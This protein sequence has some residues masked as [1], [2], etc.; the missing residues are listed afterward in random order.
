M[1]RLEIPCVDS[2]G[3]QVVF[4]SSEHEEKKVLAKYSTYQQWLKN[5][6]LTQ[7]KAKGYKPKQKIDG[8]TC[9]KCGSPV[10]DNR[11][12]KASGAYKRNAPDFVC[13][14][15][16]CN[17]GKDGK[18]WAVWPGQYELTATRVTGGGA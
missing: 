8:K 12:K 15:K 7:L 18:R 3:N 10:Y 17:G 1:A 14:N 9:P 6:G 2:E 16:Q 11:P 13:S 4:V 5:N